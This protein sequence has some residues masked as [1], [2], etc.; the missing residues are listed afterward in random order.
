MR[1]STK[2]ISPLRRRMLEDMTLRKLSAKTQAA[3]I[4]AVKNFTRFLGRAPNTATAEDLR[5]YQLHMVEQGTTSTTLNATITGLNFF[6]EVTLERP[7]VMKKMHH[8][9]QPRRLPEILSGDEVTRLFQA[10]DSLKYQAAFGAAYGAGLRA[11]EV[12]HLKVTDID[13]ERMLIRVEQGKGK[14]DR[15]A[16]LSP[17][18]LRMLRAWWREGQAK[19]QMLPGGWL[20]PGQDP[21]N[22]L[23]VR[24]LRRAFQMA[25]S[26]AA[27]DKRVSLHSLRYVLT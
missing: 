7:G 17:T 16:M 24:Q 22:P 9:Y 26:A 6:F 4:R 11:S 8:V 12:V 25:R 15:Y 13:S 27:I 20:F 2:P 18:L 14:R 5:R 1:E 21:V 10:T 19:R 3:Y 23:S